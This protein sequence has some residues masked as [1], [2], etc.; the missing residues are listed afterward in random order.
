MDN[1]NVEKKVNPVAKV[2]QAD[3]AKAFTGVSTPKAPTKES[4]K[5][6]K[7]KAMIT[8]IA[9][10]VIGLIALIAGIVVILL[11]YLGQAPVADGE[12]LT[13]ASAWVLDGEQTNCAEPAP[14]N[15]A[16]ENAEPVTTNCENAGGVIWKFTEIGKGTLTTNNHLD[17]YDFIW[18]I[19]GDKLKIETKWLYDL[20]N[21]YEYRLNQGAKTLTL[22]DDTGEYVLMGQFAETE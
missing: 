7:S 18:S 14:T 12:F 10:F 8:S 4:K 21:E 9:I 6:K 13:Q 3:L 20:V 5:S 16:T 19:E 22:K 11:K 15:E 2:S 17:D 1:S